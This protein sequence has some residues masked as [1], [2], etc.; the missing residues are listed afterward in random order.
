ML[1]GFSRLIGRSGSYIGSPELGPVDYFQARVIRSPNAPLA[2]D[3][4]A[5]RRLVDASIAILKEIDPDLPEAD[6]SPDGKVNT[7]CSPM[8]AM[9]VDVALAA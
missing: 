9:A 8:Q 1:P 7:D 5:C 2:R 4:W 3:P 6:I